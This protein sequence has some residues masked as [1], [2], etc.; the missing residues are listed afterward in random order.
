MRRVRPLSGESEQSDGRMATIS[1]RAAGKNTGARM[2]T[3]LNP[4]SSLLVFRFAAETGSVGVNK[5]AQDVAGAHWI[6]GAVLNKGIDG[7]NTRA[8]PGLILVKLFD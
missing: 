2:R 3:P 1:P 6:F 5:A 8:V 7:W 4:H